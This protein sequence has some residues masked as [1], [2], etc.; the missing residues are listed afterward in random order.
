L[1]EYDSWFPGLRREDGGL[2]FGNTPEA[3]YF[4]NIAAYRNT[5][6]GLRMN[7]DIFIE[8]YIDLITGDTSPDEF[9]KRVNSLYE[10]VLKQGVDI[11]EWYATNLGVEMTDEGLLASLMSSRVEGAVF[12]RQI[13]MAE[14]GGEAAMRN[15]DL[16][17]EFVNLLEQGG[18]DRGEAQNLFGSAQR[19]LPLLDGLAK[20]HADTDDTFDIVE[21]ASAASDIADATQMN[22]IDRLRAQEQSMFTGGGAIDVTRER[23]LRLTGLAERS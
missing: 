10:R 8:D 3:T 22:R 7:P 6:E 23:D 17:T 4:S 12:N 16:S 18:M 11:R 19:I 15:Y 2:R 9:E 21:F 20:R 14:I 1:P 5:V 13:T